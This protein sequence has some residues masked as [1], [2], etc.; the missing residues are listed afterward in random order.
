MGERVEAEDLTRMV[1]HMGEFGFKQ[2]LKPQELA[3]GR[4]QI[5][6]MPCY[7]TQKDLY[8]PE[9]VKKLI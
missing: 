5:H 6:G 7:N 3:G 9:A 1:G 8:T 4:V 2:I